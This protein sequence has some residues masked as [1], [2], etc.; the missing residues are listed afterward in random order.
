MTLLDLGEN[1]IT[2]IPNEIGELRKLQRLYLDENPISYVSPSIQNLINL[3]YLSI[4]HDMRITSSISL[5]PKTV[6]VD[7]P[8]DTSFT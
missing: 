3:E 8:I 4:D 7:M 1:E 5:L 2:K 6:E